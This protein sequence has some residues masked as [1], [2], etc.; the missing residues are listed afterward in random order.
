MT[1]PLHSPPITGGSPLLRTGPPAD[2]TTVLNIFRFSPVDALPL[3]TTRKP[4]PGYGCVDVC[5]PTFHAEAADRA[6][7]TFTPGTAWPIGGHPPGLIPGLLGY[8]GFDA[9][10]SSRRVLSG[11]L[12]FAFPVPT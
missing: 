10:S 2:A 8:P 7:A 3:T 11:S 12:A 9:I 5:L 6:R 4:E 1:R